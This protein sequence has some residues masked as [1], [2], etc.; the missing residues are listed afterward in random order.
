MNY[1]ILLSGG[2]GTRISSEIPKQYIK[3]NGRMMVTAALR[4]LLQAPQVDRV[5][6]TADPAWQQ[7]ILEDLQAASADDPEGSAAIGKPVFFA[8]PGAN[9]QLSIRNGLQQILREK[10]LRWEIMGQ[11]SLPVEEASGSPATYAGAE[12]GDVDHMETSPALGDLGPQ[13]GDSLSSGEP[14]T[15]FIHDAAR[16]Y[17]AQPLIDACYA[18]LSGHDG[19]LPVLPMKDTVYESSD[20]H[21]IDR[22]LDRSQIFAGQAP[23]LFLLEPYVA[24]N[25]ALLPDRILAINGSTEP[26]ILAGM[27]VVMIPGD[28]RNSK[29]TTNADL[30]K[31]REYSGNKTAKPAK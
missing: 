30:E 12:T 27:D 26:A 17:L 16:P 8:M 9:R 29:V 20:G 14:D 15:V 31:F 25:E 22:L 11:V 3:V 28:E 2:V 23:E 13:T 24:A 1:A 7:A 19:V 4:T 5:C 21:T 10:E 18:A 6:I